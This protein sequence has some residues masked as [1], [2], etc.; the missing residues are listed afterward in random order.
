MATIK[1]IASIA[2]VSISTVSRVLNF[3]EALNV[4]NATREKILRIADELDYV[5]SKTRKVKNKKC[6]DIGIIYWYNYEEELDDPYYLSIR[7]AAEKK[8]N[9][10]KF[11]LVK[12]ND[13]SSIE[14]IKNV[15]GVI[16]IGKFA[17]STIEKLESANENIVFVD[18]SPNDNKF[19]S[20]MADI[21]KATTEILNYLYKLGHRRIGFIGGQKSDNTDEKNLYIDERDIKYKEFME[22]KK[23]YNPEYIYPGEKYTFKTGYNLMIKAL[24]NKNRPTA[25]FIANDAMAIGAYKAISEAGLSV[26]NDISIIG[27]NDQP[28][29]KYMVPSLTTVRIPSEYLGNAAVDL[30]L[31]NINGNRE[32]N[33]KVII[34]TEFK[35]RES[36]HKI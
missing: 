22:R 30:L 17:S 8:C 24:K 25:F 3:D 12:L 11:N 16:A 34:P 4:S 32:Y 20:V 27:F 28:S 21:G 1:E 5:S 26:P 35:I 14:D 2:E 29:A 33:K 10:N 23:I 31:E 9:E 19:D 18:F 36:C 7:L 15:N 13:D 6:R